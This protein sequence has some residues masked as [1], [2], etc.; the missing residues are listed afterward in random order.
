MVGEVTSPQDGQKHRK[1][2]VIEV[3]DDNHH[4]MDMYFSGPDGAEHKAMEISYVRA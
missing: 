3:V 4:N 2:S 1:R